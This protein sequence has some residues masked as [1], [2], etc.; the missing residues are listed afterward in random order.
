LIDEI[1][2]PNQQIVKQNNQNVNTQVNVESQF[3]KSERGKAMRQIIAAFIANI[4]P[5]NTGLN[6][7]FSAVAI[8]QLRAATSDIQI[9]DSQASWVGE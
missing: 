7:G 3:D 8:P 6:F 9:D 1:K 5:I 4:G 2:Y